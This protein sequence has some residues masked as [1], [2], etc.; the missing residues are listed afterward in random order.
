MPSILAYHG[1]NGDYFAKHADNST[2][3]RYVDRP[4]ML[5]LTGEVAGQRLLDAGCGAGHYSAALVERGASVLGV[6]GSAVL[7]NHARARLGGR[8]EIWQHDL[9]TPLDSLA[10]ATFD[11]VLCAL[12]LHT[13]RPDH[14]F[15]ARCSECSVQA[16]GSH[17]PRL[18]RPSTGDTSRT[19]TSPPGVGGPGDAGRKA[20]DPVPAHVAGDPHG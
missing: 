10:N 17:S 12:V 16:A 8:A 18:T 4:A 20:L 15:S 13:Y 6:E 14:S 2:W 7:V 19:P 3:N 11:G 1:S 5:N 9:N